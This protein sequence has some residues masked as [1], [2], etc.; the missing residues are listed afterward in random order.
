MGSRG[1]R[2]RRRHPQEIVPGPTS[3]PGRAPAK[4]GGRLPSKMVVMRSPPRLVALVIA[5]AV[6]VAC[7]GRVPSPSRIRTGADAASASPSAVAVPGG[8]GDP[9]EGLA[10]GVSGGSRP[11]SGSSGS[12]LEDPS[13]GLPTR[14]AGGS[15]PS[16]SAAPPLSQGATSTDV[17]YAMAQAQASTYT[18]RYAA[19]PSLG[20]SLRVSSLNGDQA[21][22]AEDFA[23]QEARNLYRN[24]TL[25]TLCDR[26]RNAGWTC[27]RPTSQ[28]PGNYPVYLSDLALNPVSLLPVVAAVA[29]DP[30]TRVTRRWTAT[31]AGMTTR[32]AA[33][34]TPDARTGGSVTT[35]MC[36]NDS[37]V[38]L[39]LSLN[40]Y[41]SL[42]AQSYSG[43][44][45]AGAF[46]VPAPVR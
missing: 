21:V 9:T 19:K 7:G 43:A 33:W 11:E 37:G 12:G 3:G 39:L 25:T 8:A 14:R 2:P 31:V 16:S 5:L 44:V 40:Q 24:A 22:Q 35:E 45:D 13:A 42:T 4:E 36:V 28:R 38:P 23:G 29:A 30:A 15:E 32:C 6:L 18:A 17:L 46:S 27:R 1:Y 20:I 34:S 41:G 26:P 10:K